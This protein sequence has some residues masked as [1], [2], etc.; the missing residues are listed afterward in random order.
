MRKPMIII[1]P[2]VILLIA[3]VVLLASIGWGTTALSPT[4]QAL[5]P[6][7][8][9]K[10]IGST[11]ER[12]ISLLKKYDLIL[13]VDERSDS[14]SLMATV[15][16]KSS[17]NPTEIR[18]YDTHVKVQ[19]HFMNVDGKLLFVGEVY[20]QS[21]AQDKA[22]Q[23]IKD[24]GRILEGFAFKSEALTNKRS[25]GRYFDNPR[26]WTPEETFEHTHG[27]S[28]GWAIQDEKDFE[29]VKPFLKDHILDPSN[30]YNIYTCSAIMMSGMGPIQK[31][32]YAEPYD[33]Q[34]ID[35]RIRI[36]PMSLRN[37]N[38]QPII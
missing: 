27:F 28:E 1:V 21:Y 25:P 12:M 17:H 31:D 24:Y 36:W 30:P 32:P 8:L 29:C 16:D 38:D 9:A 33:D 23:A 35:M 15:A 2:A 20:Y 11:Q 34:A 26:G 13:N 22:K 6:A 7:S 10:N 19:L 4:D 3:A 14:S 18:L 37:E 5:S